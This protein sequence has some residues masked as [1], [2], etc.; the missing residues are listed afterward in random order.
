VLVFVALTSPPAVLYAI[1]VERFM[2][3]EAAQATNIWFLA[4]VATWRVA[5]LFVFLLRVAALRWFEVLAAGLLPLTLI[6]S[7]LTAL[8]LE[9]VV[10]DLMGGLAPEQRTGNDGAYGVLMVITV[11]SVFTFPVLA[12]AWMVMVARV[13]RRARQGLAA[14]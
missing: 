6:V 8:N 3:L 9:H 1:P 7:A 14:R 2:T 11:F 10:F 13:Q 5:L 12:I 4:T